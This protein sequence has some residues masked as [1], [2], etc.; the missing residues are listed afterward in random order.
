MR[1][2]LARM[3]GRIKTEPFH[4]ACQMCP[5]NRDTVGGGCESGARPKT[6]SD[7]QAGYAAAF[8][9]WYDHKIE[10]HMAVNGRNPVG[11]QYQWC[12]AAIFEPFDCKFNAL[13][14]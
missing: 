4:K 14:R 13:F 1:H 11:F 6:C 2:G 3:T 8:T 12:A 5:Q 7:R 9:L 10:L